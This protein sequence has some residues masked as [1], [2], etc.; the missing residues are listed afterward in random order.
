MRTYSNPVKPKRAHPLHS[1]LGKE[2][3]IFPTDIEHVRG[4]N[5]LMSVF[6]A[7]RVENTEHGN[8]EN[9]FG[10]L[11]LPI[12]LHLHKTNPLV[13]ITRTRRDE[14][15]RGTLRLRNISPPPDI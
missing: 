12:V 7:S 15:L 10:K 13:P 9:L 14:Y 5:L 4:E 2:L 8:D 11:F 1:Y 3:K 6:S